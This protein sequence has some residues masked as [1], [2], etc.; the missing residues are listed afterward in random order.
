M[1]V[2]RI[3]VVHFGIYMTVLG[4]EVGFWNKSNSPHLLHFGYVMKQS[5]NKQT[6]I[7]FGFV[8]V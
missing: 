4:L 7:P 5:Q 8:V 6:R 2:M 3:T 1:T